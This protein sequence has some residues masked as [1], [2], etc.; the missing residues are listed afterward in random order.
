MLAASPWLGRVWQDSDEQAPVE[1]E[2]ETRLPEAVF[3]TVVEVM[4]ALL[5]PC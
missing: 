2:N 5:T 3:K 4:A 1:T